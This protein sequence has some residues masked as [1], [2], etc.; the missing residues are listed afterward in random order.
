MGD[1]PPEIG[2]WTVRAGKNVF[3][4]SLLQ[5]FQLVK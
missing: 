3:I 5:N 2:E 4:A 1:K